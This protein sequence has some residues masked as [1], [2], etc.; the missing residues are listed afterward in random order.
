M[1]SVVGRSLR[2]RFSVLFKY[3]NEHQ[4]VKYDSV[5]KI[6]QVGIT[7]YAQKELGDI[8]HVES[9]KIGLK[10]K[11]SLPTGAIE[12][13]KVAADI[14]APV[15][16]E[17]VNINDEVKNNPSLINEDAERYWI[18]EAKVDNQAEVEQLM[19]KEQ[20]LEFLKGLVH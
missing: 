18:Y 9:P 16:G 10:F 8:V 2:Y 15:S 17:V 19:T 1:Y 11:K 13:V 5:T 3:T 12:S 20:Y 7:D 6:A 4:W 14:Y